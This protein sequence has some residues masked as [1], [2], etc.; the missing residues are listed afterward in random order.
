MLF[1]P[2]IILGVALSAT[3]IPIPSGPISRSLVDLSPILSPKLKLGGNDQCTG[4]GISVCD[5]INVGGEQSKSNTE[6]SH[7][8]TSNERETSQ[9]SDSGDGN[10]SLLNLSPDISPDISLGGDSDCFG[11]GISACDPINVNGSQQ[12]SN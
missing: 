9:P 2:T 12:N 5:P 1:T 10:A 6:A 8:E 4:I 3:A 11:V 7:G